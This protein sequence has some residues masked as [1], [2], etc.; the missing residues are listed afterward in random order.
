MEKFQPVNISFGLL[1]EAQDAGRNR[2][3]DRKERHRIRVE[4]ALRDMDHWIKTREVQ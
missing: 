2:I 1:G 4:E 3:R